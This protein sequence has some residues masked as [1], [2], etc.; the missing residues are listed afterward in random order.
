MPERL[1]AL[2]AFEI[3]RPEQV[4]I[5]SDSAEKVRF[6][7]GDTVYKKGGKAGIENG[8]GRNREAVC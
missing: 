3:L 8:S 5:L 2:G 7:A 1:T 4:H 6:D